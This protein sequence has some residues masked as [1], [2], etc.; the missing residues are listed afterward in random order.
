MHGESPVSNSPSQK[1]PPGH[2]RAVQHGEQGQK[3]HEDAGDAGSGDNAERASSAASP[4][5]GTAP[6]SPLPNGVGGE[7]CG[8]SAMVVMSLAVTGLQL[9]KSEAWWSHSSQRQV[10]G[11]RRRILSEGVGNGL[12]AG[13]RR[14]EPEKVA[15]QAAR[16]M[17]SL[18]TSRENVSKASG[19][20]GSV[21]GV[22]R[23][24][25]APD[26]RAPRHT[27]TRRASRGGACTIPTEL[28]ARTCP[29]SGLG[30]DIPAKAKHAAVFVIHGQNP[31]AVVAGGGQG[32]AA[33][34]HGHVEA[35]GAAAG[36][37]VSFSMVKS[38]LSGAVSQ[39]DGPSGSSKNKSGGPEAV[40]SAEG[41]PPVVCK[42][43]VSPLVVVGSGAAAGVMLPA[44]YV[45]SLASEKLSRTLQERRRVA[46]RNVNLVLDQSITEI[47][48]Q[49]P[50]GLS[51]SRSFDNLL[52]SLARGP[53]Y[54]LP[55]VHMLRRSQSDKPKSA[56]KAKG[57]AGRGGAGSS[58]PKLHRHR[59]EGASFAQC[60]ASSVLQR[61]MCYKQVVCFV[62]GC[63]RQDL[64]EL[65][66]ALSLPITWSMVSHRTWEDITNVSH[67]SML[68]LSTPSVA[69]NIDVLVQLHG[70]KLYLSHRD[71]LPDALDSSGPAAAATA[72]EDS[73]TSQLFLESSTL[74][75]V[76]TLRRDAPPP[77]PAAREAKAGAS[78]R[79]PSGPL[80]RDVVC[81][82]ASGKWQVNMFPPAVGVAAQ[83]AQLLGGDAL[84]IA[85]AAYIS[86][87]AAARAAPRSAART[88]FHTPMLLRR[89]AVSF[90]DEATELMEDVDLQ[91]GGAA[92]AGGVASWAE[93]AAAMR[94]AQ[95]QRSGGDGVSLVLP[96]Q[97]S[98]KHVSI[99]DTESKAEGAR[100][101]RGASMAAALSATE[102]GAG[103]GG[104]GWAGSS[105]KYGRMHRRTGSLPSA[106]AIQWAL[107]ISDALAA[108]HAQRGQ[109]HKKLVPDSS[110]K[111]M[112]V[113]M[114]LQISLHAEIQAVLPRE[115]RWSVSLSSASAALT[116]HP[117]PLVGASSA[118]LDTSLCLSFGE[119]ALQLVK[120]GVETGPRIVSSNLGANLLSSS[121]SAAAL[122]PAADSTAGGSA[123]AGANDLKAEVLRSKRR[124]VT[125]TLD[126]DTL[127]VRDLHLHEVDGTF[128][129]KMMSAWIPASIAIRAAH[130]SPSRAQYQVWRHAYATG[131]AVPAARTSA[132][133]A[134]TPSKAIALDLTLRVRNCLADVRVM[135]NVGLTYETYDKGQ[136]GLY[137]TIS[138][139]SKPVQA[140]SLAKAGS[141]AASGARN[142]GATAQGKL[143]SQSEM[144]F[145]LHKSRLR[146]DKK[147]IESGQLLSQATFYFPDVQAAG[148][149]KT[150]FNTFAPAPPPPADPA[151]AAGGSGGGGG[152]GG[153]AVAGSI[154]SITDVNITFSIKE[155]CNEV[156]QDMLNFLLEM[157]R[158]MKMELNMFLQVPQKSPTHRTKRVLKKSPF[159]SESPVLK[160]FTND[161]LDMLLHSRR[162]KSMPCP[163]ARS[164]RCEPLWA[165]RCSGASVS[166][167]VTDSNCQ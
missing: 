165:C 120:Q 102:G 157:Q 82:L 44:A 98:L 141:E 93:A 24:V 163:S 55:K 133:H 155:M 74:V 97:G 35:D 19:V 100:G 48:R 87:D 49:S 73:Q 16:H 166:L 150:R 128:A 81:Q 164:A 148:T 138:H 132:A 5:P 135:R 118:H 108:S 56:L 129:H 1:A 80:V 9:V 61:E 59:S 125:V 77:A 130:S 112:P 85:R 119:V 88:T 136:R 37:L 127:E 68:A 50:N 45:W 8:E 105:G 12:G 3:M 30:G 78:V 95:Q 52:Q 70:I 107:D 106:S 67:S 99:A 147:D 23:I 144:C 20:C 156:R 160:S 27:H 41:E 116:R 126:M 92:A 158:T 58:V 42:A 71:P 47:Q 159:S 123:A 17:R 38:S 149:I 167:T 64:M 103:G 36:S 39:Q 2:E 13:E 69:L 4:S 54:Q 151:V 62:R 33:R 131:A 15:G 115:G 46:D 140:S 7:L 26:A 21:Q 43:T 121:V 72:Q 143:L 29:G 65:D 11:R 60:A 134:S 14:N 96:F 53:Q 113:M 142:D 154:P 137:A 51:R 40:G 104:W 79:G 122:K 18:Y 75:C 66:A 89:R 111:K 90:K 109:Q 34:K 32:S 86:L 153:G 84:H 161:G 6:P 146:T 91:R 94:E 110:P 63:S 25:A 139:Y 145:R 57:S 152:G 114:H 10:A 31:D 83:V 22:V 162:R 124:H 76:S 101:T 117:R 28:L